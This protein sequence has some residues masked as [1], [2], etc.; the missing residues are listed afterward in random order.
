M[1]IKGTI[2]FALVAALCVGA[3]S[4]IYLRWQEFAPM[5]SWVH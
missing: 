3:A 2:A 1:N 5:A 4:V